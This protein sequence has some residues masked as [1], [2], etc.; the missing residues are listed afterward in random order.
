MLLLQIY[1]CYF[2]ICYDFCFLS[3]YDISQNHLK[4][5]YLD[6]LSSLSNFLTI[7]TLIVTRNFDICG[8]LKII[9]V[10]I[11]CFK[12]YPMK[13]MK[14]GD[15]VTVIAFYPFYFTLNNTYSVI[16]SSLSVF[17]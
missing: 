10:G 4:I 16:E 13:K 15:A 9:E 12:Y 1:F 14:I 5:H 8:C 6:I 17:T 2:L 3:H 11:T 7:S